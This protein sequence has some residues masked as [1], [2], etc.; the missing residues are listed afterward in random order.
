MKK[1]FYLVSLLLLLGIPVLSYGKPLKGRVVLIDKHDK[2]S[3]AE[4]VD[5]TLKETGDTVRTK[6]QGLFRMFIPDDFR[7]GENVTFL[8]GTKKLWS[9]DRIE[10][11]IKTK[12]AEKSKEQIRPGGSPQGIDF[13]EAIKE[14]A[15]LKT[16]EQQLAD[17]IGSDL[18]LA[19]DAAYNDYEFQK[20]IENYENALSF[21]VKDK[22]PRLWASIQIEIG[23]ANEQQGI[24]TES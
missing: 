14:W 11:F 4:G 2:T 15:A 21:V 7:A 12:L 1:L 8:V 22:Q 24:R 5:V 18:H 20:A 19:G 23:N 10:N 3:P 16:Q 6:A 17:K 9:G 13:S